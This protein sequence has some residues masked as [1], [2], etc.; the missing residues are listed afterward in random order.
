MTTNDIYK[1]LIK[2]K[3]EFEPVVFDKLNPHFRSKY[4]SL[5]SIKKAIE[6]ALEKYGFIVTQPWESLENGDIRLSTVLIHESGERIA[7]ASSIIK[8][9]KTDQQLG[10]SMT[11]IRRYQI[12]SALFLFAEEDDDGETAEG[13][14]C[15]PHDLPKKAK[16]AIE[17]SKGLTQDQLNAI[18]LKI[19]DFPEIR[20][21]ILK[22]YGKKLVIDIPQ[23]KFAA[24]MKMIDLRL[25]EEGAA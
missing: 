1:N 2:A 16:P 4:A 9:G 20:D 7:L 6:P 18:R 19:K 11:Y 24:V 3:G 13:N 5:A 21:E 8:A 15:P 22:T 25:E 14:V 17:E 23:E 12:S 10:G